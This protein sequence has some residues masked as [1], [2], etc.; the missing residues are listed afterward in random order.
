MNI[1]F[2]SSFG[3]YACLIR[4]ATLG[5]YTHC[6][7]EIDGVVYQAKIFKGVYKSE[8]IASEWD[9]E[10]QLFVNKEDT[11][12]CVKFLESELGCGYDWLGVIKFVIPWIKAS[13]SRW[14]CSEL[15]VAALQK[16]KKLDKKIVACRCSPSK[17]YELL[18]E[19]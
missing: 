17:V 5:R 1:L 7:V 19:C 8:Y 14:F 15:V 4:L 2:K 6:A 9:N 16:V 12:K 3:L 10:V 11:K 18:I 13:K